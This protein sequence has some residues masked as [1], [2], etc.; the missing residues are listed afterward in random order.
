MNLS[1]LISKKVM[2]YKFIYQINMLIIKK[3]LIILSF[4]QKKI[5]L[6]KKGTPFGIPL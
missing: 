5:D 6:N 3:S 1:I 2:R 4:I